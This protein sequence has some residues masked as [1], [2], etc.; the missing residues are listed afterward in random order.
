MRQEIINVLYTYRNAF[1]SDK[2]ALGAIKGHKV[3]VTLNIHRLYPPVLRRPAYPASARYRE[4]L[5]KHIEE[6]I[7]LDVLRTLGHRIQGI[8][9]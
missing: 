1:A 3:G 2:E 5:E 8:L 7:Q 6:L 9:T 4:A